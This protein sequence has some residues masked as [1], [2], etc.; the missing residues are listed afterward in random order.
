VPRQLNIEDV[1]P[2]IGNLS[3]S[4]YYQVQFGG[5]SPR[6][7]GYLGSRGV[8]SAFIS[9]DSGLLCYSA[10]LP[11]SSLAGTE[12]TNFTGITET[13]AHRRVFTSLSLEFY[14]DSN[15][16]SLKFLE[17]WMEYVASGNGF[18][19][20]ADRNYTYRMNYP[21]DPVSG[22]KCDSTKIYKFESDVQRVMEYSF[23]GLFPI[24]LSSTPVRYGPTSELT[25]VTCE[26]RYDRYIAGSILSYDT[27]RG[28]GNNL[29]SGLTNAFSDLNFNGFGNTLNTINRI[30]G[31]V[32]DILNLFTN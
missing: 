19:D 28:F 21:N 30:A 22:Y 23:L 27:V 18:L 26:F 17:H 3:R 32:S 5:L 9:E 31:P 11:G 29:E 2:L 8:D 16:R 15:Y 12:S 14:C 1:K 13:M 25:R 7:R 10:Q 24:N 20:Y 4:N 6:L